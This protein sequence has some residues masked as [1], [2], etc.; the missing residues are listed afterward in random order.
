VITQLFAIDKSVCIW[1]RAVAVEEVV[2]VRVAAH[3]EELV[4]EDGVA[5]VI[6]RPEPRSV[7]IR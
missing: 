6:K 1:D 2:E 5:I 7:A 3:I 4:Q